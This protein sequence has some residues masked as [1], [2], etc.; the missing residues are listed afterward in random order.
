M[1]LILTIFIA[2]VKQ[3]QKE[4]E[5]NMEYVR[6]NKKML[7]K[8]IVDSL[9]LQRKKTDNLVHRVMFDQEKDILQKLQARKNRTLSLPHKKLISLLK[10]GS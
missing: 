5:L 1:I 4:I 9:N 7:T 8:E 6:K 3:K 10:K 2:E